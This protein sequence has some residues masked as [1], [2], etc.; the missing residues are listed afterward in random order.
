M[1]IED[2]ETTKHKWFYGIVGPVLLFAYGFHT[3]TTGSFHWRARYSTRMILT[4]TD[5]MAAACC[6]ITG[7][8]VLHFYAFW[9]NEDRLSS[10]WIIGAVPALIAF[11]LSIGWL[12]FRQFANFI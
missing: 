9:Q 7:A 1:T 4:G 12:L 11:I 3:I 10:Y 8:L 5:A 6:L 2:A